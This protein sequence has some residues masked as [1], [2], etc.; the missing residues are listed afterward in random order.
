MFPSSDLTLRLQS[1]QLNRITS[2]TTEQ[3]NSLSDDTFINELSNELASCLG[4]DKFALINQDG[5]L[6]NMLSE[7]K[8]V[9]K[10]HF[11]WGDYTLR[12]DYVNFSQKG[13]VTIEKSQGVGDLPILHKLEFISPNIQGLQ[14]ILT[15]TS[16]NKL[17][18]GMDAWGHS[19]K[20]GASNEVEKNVDMVLIKILMLVVNKWK[21]L[22]L[23]G[24][25][26]SSLP[27]LPEW[28]E[29]LSV[30]HNQLSTIQVPELCKDLDASF[31][32]LTEFPKMPDDTTRININNNMISRIDSFPSKAEEIYISCNNLSEISELPVG[33]KVFD[34]SFNQITKIQYFP[35]NLEEAHIQNNNI[36]VL[37]AL[38]KNLQLLSIEGNPIKEPF[39]TPWNLKKLDMGIDQAKYHLGGY[40]G[41]RPYIAKGYY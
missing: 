36:Q 35:D 2:N 34:C 1:G 5:K 14:E 39:K 29:K 19:V 11:K 40:C 26:L 13:C 25:Q 21:S 32:N 18:E 6:L 41:R 31:N 4:G 8:F 7:F 9:S 33:T 16:F 12:F 20:T 24:L 10:E 30:S 23:S 38:Y 17:C 27:P 37:P 28:I 3:Q 22:D 15:A